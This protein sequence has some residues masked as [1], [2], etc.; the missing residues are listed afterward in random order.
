MFTGFFA[1]FEHLILALCITFILNRLLNHSKK[2]KAIDERLEQLD[3][4]KMETWDEYLSKL[5][6][7]T[8][9]NAHELM[10]IAAQESGLNFSPDRVSEDFRSFIHDGELPNYVV[11]FLKKGKE[12]IDSIDEGPTFKSPPGMF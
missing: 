6:R 4:G 2:A 3:S 10:T 11:M 5:C 1:G 12:K 7:I 8:G 9:K